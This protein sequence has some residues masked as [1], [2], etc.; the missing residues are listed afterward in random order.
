MYTVRQVSQ[1]P[2]E[3]IV[4]YV[5]DHYSP[6]VHFYANEFQLRYL[7]LQFLDQEGYL[8]FHDSR[9]LQQPYIGKIYVTENGD[10]LATVL[11]F[12]IN[13]VPGLNYLTYVY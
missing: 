2:I 8:D 9:I 11:H 7:T 6:H 13:L 4:R 5:R 3:E 12:F 10:T 1:I